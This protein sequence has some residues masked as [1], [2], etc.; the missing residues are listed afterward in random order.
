MDHALQAVP[1]RQQ[2][3]LVLRLDIS[4]KAVGNGHLVRQV[5]SPRRAV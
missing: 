4:Q 2:H 1:R 5:Q 3:H